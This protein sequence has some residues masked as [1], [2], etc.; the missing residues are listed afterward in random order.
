[1]LWAPIHTESSRV[2]AG[3]STRPF[4]GATPPH[5]SPSRIAMGRVNNRVNSAPTG[6]TAWKQ[7]S[8]KNSSS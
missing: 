7:N 2:I 1:M 6:V 5:S 3:S 8:F 4:R